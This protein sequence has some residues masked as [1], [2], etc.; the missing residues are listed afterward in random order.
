MKRITNTD[1]IA[2]NSRSAGEELRV[3]RERRGLSL[4]ELAKATN[5][6][7]GHVSNVEHDTKPMTRG[8]ATAC[9]AAL[10]TGGALSDLITTALRPRGRGRTVPV[11]QLPVSPRLV[12]RTA[13]LG[14]LSSAWAE[15]SRDVAS[16]VIVIDGTAGVGK[17]ALAVAWGHSVSGSFTDGV[18]F[19]DLHGYA[20]DA[21]AADPHGVLEDFLRSFGV[22]PEDIPSSTERRAATWRSVLQGTRTLVVLDNAADAEQ[23]R[24]LLPG[25]AG[26]LAVVTSRRRMSG[27]VVREGARCVTVEPLRG[28]GASELLAEIVGARRVHD[29]PAIAKSIGE[30]C[31]RL[32]LAVRIAGERIAAHP[33]RSLVSLASELAAAD[34][35][36]DVLSPSTDGDAIRAVLSWSYRALP[37]SAARVFR[38]LGLHPGQ[39][40]SVP[41]VAALV[42]VREVEASTCLDYLSSVHLIEAVGPDRF[43]QHDLLKA[44]SLE[45]VR[46]EDP[47]HEQDAAVRRVLDW[48]LQTLYVAAHALAPQRSNPTLAPPL[49]SVFTVPKTLTYEQAHVWFEAETPNLVICTERAH[50][51]ELHV[52]AWQFAAGLW[53]WLHLCKAWT[54]WIRTHTTGLAAARADKDPFGEAW[55]HNNLANAHRELR[56]FDDARHHFDRALALRQE[57]GDLIG[58]AWTLTGSGF[59]ELDLDHSELANDLFEQS[60]G[61]FREAGDHHGEAIALASLGEAQRNLDQPDLALHHL[62]MALEI[63]RSGADRYGEAFTLIR[64]ARTYQAMNLHVEALQHFDLALTTQRAIGDR[65]GQAETLASA[66]HTQLA[67]GDITGAEAAWHHALVIFDE[68]NDPHAEDIRTNLSRLVVPD[69][70]QAGED[71]PAVVSSDQT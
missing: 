3:L 59:L 56:N 30:L 71:Q 2:A 34:E 54:V 28:S 1:E 65:W 48:Y 12:G 36:L 68:L 16:G 41:A 58:Q 39:R 57:V 6:S 20:A 27:L 50:D 15:M 7:V 37:A 63:M 49:D 67:L 62:G 40:F 11:A 55:I 42:G 31:A 4:S 61:L 8:F 52:Q 18:L 51:A 69:Q 47:S 10:Q 60:L 5:Y 13:E 14:A 53:D 19:Y 24:P 66:G 46:A 44:Y 21:T 33:H 17:T 45:R 35:R 32:P 9:D 38:F 23:V 25:A 22:A 26:C 64:M 70:R 29:E 43:R